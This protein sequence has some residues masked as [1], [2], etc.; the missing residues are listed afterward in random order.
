MEF[1]KGGISRFNCLYLI[2]SVAS[3]FGFLQG[4]LPDLAMA[5]HAQDIKGHCLK[6]MTCFPCQ[7]LTT[8]VCQVSQEKPSHSKEK[9]L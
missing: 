2:S 4:T 9:Y 3:T 6:L 1:K 7:A 8:P 5:P